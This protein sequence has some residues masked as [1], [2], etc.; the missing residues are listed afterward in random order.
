MRR[1]RTARSPVQGVYPEGSLAPVPFPPRVLQEFRD[2]GSRKPDSAPDSDA[3]NRTLDTPPARSFVDG[4]NAHAKYRGNLLCIVDGL[5]EPMIVGLHGRFRRTLSSMLLNQVGSTSQLA[6][7]KAAAKP[8]QPD[9][10]VESLLRGLRFDLILKPH[11]NAPLPGLGASVTHGTALREPNSP[12]CLDGRLLVPTRLIVTLHPPRPST[13]RNLSGRP[14]VTAF[15]Q[16][17]RPPRDSA[18]RCFLLLLLVT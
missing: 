2:A 3:R 8:M 5:I 1:G 12:T 17:G 4:R 11:F 13:T 9:D 6:C 18:R 10:R 14:R 16:L 15:E 7:V